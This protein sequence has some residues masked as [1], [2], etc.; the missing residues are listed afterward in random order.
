M[1]AIPSPNSCCVDESIGPEIR[2]NS[3]ELLLILSTSSP[4]HSKE[5]VS[6]AGN[7]IFVF[8]SPEWIILS[9]MVTESL[10]VDMA[11]DPKSG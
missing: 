3:A 2:S 11:C 9:P 8:V 10:V 5:I 1:T 7:L 4:A 6:A